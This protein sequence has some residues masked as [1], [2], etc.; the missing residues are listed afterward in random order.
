M[1]DY[2][3]I[4]IVLWQVFSAYNYGNKIWCTFRTREK[5]L[6]GKW[7]KAND[8]TVV[9]G[10]GK[11]TVDPSRV[12]L[13]IK[14]LPLPMWVKIADF[15]YNS[16]LALEPHSFDNSLTPE[17]RT[18]LDISDAVEGYTRGGQKALAASK[19]K[20]FM[21]GWLPIL[22]IAGIVII[23]YLVYKQQARIDLLGNGQNAIQQQLSQIIERLGK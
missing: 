5:T 12:F 11:Y 13:G 19:K 23:G 16:P 4:F 2:G 8:G 22:L 7:V 14:W 1:L 21:E 15:R 20:G 17:R 9:F 6:I 3:L 10:R 18:Q